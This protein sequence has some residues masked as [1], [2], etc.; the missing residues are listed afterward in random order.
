[1]RRT[2]QAKL[3]AEKSHHDDYPLALAR[4]PHSLVQRI[5]LERRTTNQRNAACDIA[6]LVVV[7]SDSCTR[8]RINHV[9]IASLRSAP[10]EID[11][12]GRRA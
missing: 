9:V 2:N 10:V 12:Y 3:R 8:Y 6:T 7:N 11:K 5:S 1:M 4:H